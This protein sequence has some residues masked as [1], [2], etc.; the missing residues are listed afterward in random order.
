MLAQG[1]TTLTIFV[2]KSQA[3]LNRSRSYHRAKLPKNPIANL[4]LKLFISSTDQHT[5]LVQSPVPT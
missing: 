5:L 1:L 2:S 3:W 4:F